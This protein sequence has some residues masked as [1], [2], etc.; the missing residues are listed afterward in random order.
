MNYAAIEDA[1][2]E[3]LAPLKQSLGVR[4]IKSYGGEFSP[5]DIGQI[6]IIFPAI[7]IHI[8]EMTNQA[9]NRLDMRTFIIS[10]FV[11]D[12]SSRGDETARR[13]D[14][15]IGRPGVYTLLEA[16]RTALH[17]K[18]IPGAGTLYLQRETNIGY[19]KSLSICISVAEYKIETKNNP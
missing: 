6:A 16:V 14:A 9:M 19:S 13:G 3:K 8:P 18:S 4:E 2:I 5:D 10:V 1:V 12:Q 15:T 17:K 7:F 11:A